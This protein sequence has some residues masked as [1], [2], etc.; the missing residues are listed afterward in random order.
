MIKIRQIKI[1]VNEDENNK[2]LQ[3]ISKKLKIALEDIEEYKITKK[4]IDARN[5]KEIY[6]VYEVVVKVK[7]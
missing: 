1:L 5:K 3:K 2:L 7:N 4:A 6:F